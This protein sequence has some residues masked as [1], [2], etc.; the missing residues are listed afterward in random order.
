MRRTGL[1]SAAALALAIAALGALTTR[2][3]YAAVVPGTACSVFPSDNI[4][5]TDISS[6]PV[7]SNSGAWL[8][9]TGAN[10]GRKLHPDFGP[11]A[12]GIPFNVVSSSHAT[13][14]FTFLYASESDPG[15][16][17]YGSDLAIEAPTDSH[18]LTI[19]K[20]TCKLY[21]TG[22]TNYNGPST[23]WAGAIFDLTSNQLRPNTWT[24]ADAAGLPIFPGL[25]RLD[26]IQAG[27]IGHAIRFTVQRSDT[28]YL[29]PARHQ[30][31][32]TSD[33]TLPPMGARFRLKAS[34]DISGYSPQAQVVLTAFKHYGL[35]VADN[36]SNWFFQGSVDPGWGNPPYDTVISGLKNVPANQ[37][38][39]IDESSL[40]V[41]PNSAQ[42][43]T[44]P[45]APTA[46][47]ASPRDAAATVSW[48]APATGGQPIASYA[49]T[50]TPSGHAV[51]G[52]ASTTAVVFGLTNGISYTFR[53]TATNVIGTGPPSPASNA[54]IPDHRLTGQS[55]PPPIGTRSGANQSTTHAP[56]PRVPRGPQ[57]AAASPPV[58]AMP[59][60]LFLRL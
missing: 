8:N 4:W 18:L 38:E 52:G 7:N 30:A 23:A 9:S 54:V 22:G 16:Y 60:I 49:I 25:V 11:P 6:M 28:S 35:I 42:A 10:L 17:P 58:G 48:T 51:V 5:N 56:G 41:D 32:A 15:L 43:G 45:A 40:M 2:P 13:T 29:W 55:A 50:G 24:S 3:V 59:R 39:A 47:T 19:N 37:F 21:E 46:P 44:V 53:V 26:E 57:Q 31:G 27:F 36:G 12:Y 1:A 34:Y 14:T 20:D 33:P